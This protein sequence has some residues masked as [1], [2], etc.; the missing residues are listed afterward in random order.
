MSEILSYVFQPLIKTTASHITPLNKPSK[1]IS[2]AENDIFVKPAHS[3]KP[4]IKQL[5][6]DRKQRTGIP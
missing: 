6:T 3:Q 4:T 5:S 1:T 2:S